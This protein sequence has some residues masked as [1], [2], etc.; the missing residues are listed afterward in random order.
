MTSFLMMVSLAIVAAALYVLY[1]MYEARGGRPSQDYYVDGL[2]AMVRKDFR[3]AA[4][5]FRQAVEADSDHVPAYEKLGN[6]YRE[7]G[8]IRRAAKIHRELTVRSGLAPDQL[9]RIQLSLCD[10][11]T[12]LGRPE[13]ARQ[14]V[15]RAAQADR[16]NIAVQLRL[17][18]IHEAAG[19]PEEAMAALKRVEAL[20]HQDLKETRARIKVALARVQI[21]AGKGRAGRV[22]LKEALKDHPRCFAAMLLIG[23]S[24]QLENRI[25]EALQSW[26][27]VPFEVPEEGWQVFERIEKVYF[28]SGRFGDVESLYRRVIQKSPENPDAWV[29]LA[30][31]YERKGELDQAVT[32][33]RDGL[34]K[35]GRSIDVARMMIRLLGRKGD[36]REL[37]VF[38]SQLVER[39]MEGARRE[40]RKRAVPPPGGEASGDGESGEE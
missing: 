4:Q 9:A 30:Q 13:E 32:L 24:Y 12:R 27:R 29:A 39:L 2:D 34:E 1:R 23:D 38:T 5:C 19:R 40:R 28:E 35:T 3:E 10:D 37:I 31:F 25:D 11:L 15:E 21:A 36:S 18:E 7:L 6:V 17:M 33:C 16:R 22:L 8:D 26:E 14:A 20:G